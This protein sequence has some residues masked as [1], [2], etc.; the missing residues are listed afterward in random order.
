MAYFKKKESHQDSDADNRDVPFC[1][2]ERHLA[3]VKR[4]FKDGRQIGLISGMPGVGK[5]RLAKEVAFQM[6]VECENQ[7]IKLKVNTFNLSKFTSTNLI[8]DTICASMLQQNQTTVSLKP[9][10][11]TAALQRLNLEEDFHLFICDNAD[12]ILDD[13]RLRTELLDFISKIVEKTRNVLF[14]VTSR[15]RF[16][17]AREY[18]LFF[19]V[20]LSPLTPDEAL[21]LLAAI[22][23]DVPLQIHGAEITKMCGYLPLALVIAGVEL[24]RGEDGYT[25]EELIELL[26]KNVLESPLSAESYSR[27]EQ[28]SHVLKS[29]IGKLTDVIKSHFAALNYIPGS[30]GTSAAAAIAGKQSPAHAKAD[31]I[32]P[33]RERSLLEFDSSQQ[34][35]D[36]HPLMRDLVQQSLGQFVDVGI[37]RQRFCV[38]FADVLKK[39]GL[40]MNSDASRG[41]QDLTTE[42]KNIEKMMLEAVNCADEDTHG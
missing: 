28:V 23:T 17:L 4:N 16:R 12:T 40:A 7:N 29:A 35:F 37:T 15:R 42:I 11:L 10:N 36:I 41:L 25:P 18:R 2:R 38:F 1:G 5:T 26:R 21:D 19:D 9:E 13:D 34:R 33:L 14:L 22:A 31:V 32:R 27:S 20:E 3:A 39:I 8:I 24:Q 6:S 30:F